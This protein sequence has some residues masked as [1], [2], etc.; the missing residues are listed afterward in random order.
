MSPSP[1]NP[2][3]RDAWRGRSDSAE[4]LSA[5]LPTAGLAYLRQA[6]DNP[7][8]GPSQVVFL[9]KNRHANRELLDRIRSDPRFA[10]LREVRIGL[11]GHPELARPEAVRLLGLLGWRDLVRVIDQPRTPAP[12]TRQAGL[13]LRERIDGLA[14]GEL[15]TL[16]RIAPREVIPYLLNQ[17]DGRVVQA[18]LGNPR[19]V[20]NDVLAMARQRGAGAERLA[21][22]SRSEKW[23]A[24][25]AVRWALVENPATPPAEAL[26]CV[27]H[28]TRED[29]RRVAE[30]PG[31]SRLVRVGAER[32]LR[33]RGE[34]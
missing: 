31:V 25:A 24:S 5:H 21:A 8:L 20:E 15:M 14:L 19:L 26:N 17:R 6:L 1:D 29:R 12:V 28:M 32:S 11:A 18:L 2:P 33:D 13:M 27:R 10:D 30:H 23:V 9:L 7:S 16:A 22:V 34:T 3:E 4:E